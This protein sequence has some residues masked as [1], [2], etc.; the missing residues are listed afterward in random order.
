MKKNN[1][2]FLDLDGVIVVGDKDDRMYPWGKHE[3]FDMRAVR[4][5]N[6]IYDVIPFDIVLSSDWRNQFSMKNLV[7]MFE[8]FKVKANIVGVTRN[9]VNYIGTDL[10][11]GRSEEI[12]W[13]VDA[14]KDEIQA[15]VSVD[16]LKMYQLEHFVE[17]PKWLEGIKQCG[18]KEKIIKELKS[19]LDE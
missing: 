6:S 19:Q 16:D 3:P 2:V 18:I 11:G 9:S 7:S 10:E 13:Y 17:C 12:N 15:W 5:L 8:F 4:V 1:I 14:H